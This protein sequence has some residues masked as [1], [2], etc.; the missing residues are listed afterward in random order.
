M[1]EFWSVRKRNNK[2]VC[3]KTRLKSKIFHKKDWNIR[4]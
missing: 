4:K 2:F 1:A 3:I